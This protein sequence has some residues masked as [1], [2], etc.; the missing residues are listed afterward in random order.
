MPFMNGDTSDNIFHKSLPTVQAV[1]SFS[2]TKNKLFM[3][4][5]NRKFLNTPLNP[6]RPSRR[7]RLAALFFAAWG[8]L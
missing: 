1:G 3:K 2:P 8:M 6:A 4:S 5:K 7:K